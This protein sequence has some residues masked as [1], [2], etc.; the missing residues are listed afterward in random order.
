MLV[1]YFAIVS[2]GLGMIAV[3]LFRERQ[4]KADLQHHRNAKKEEGEPSPDFVEI[5]SEKQ[6]QE[7]SLLERYKRLEILFEEKSKELEKAQTALANELELRKEF[8]T[9]KDLLENKILQLKN[10]NQVLLLY[11]LV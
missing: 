5:V 11:R 1:F 9:L 4:N 7:Q 10:E 6:T 8:T 2:L 3:V